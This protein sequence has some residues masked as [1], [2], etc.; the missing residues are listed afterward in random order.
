MSN[1]PHFGGRTLARSQALQLLFQAEAGDRSVEDVLDDGP[2]LESGPLDPYGR[3][4]ALG[5]EDM[6]AELDSVIA[7]RSVGWSVDRM[8]AVDRNLLRIALYEMLRVDEVDIA[9]AI[10]E[11][12]ELEKAYGTDESPRF[13]NGLLGVVADQIEEGKDPV[14]TAREQLRAA[15]K[16]VPG[17]CADA[18]DADE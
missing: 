18:G 13:A 5:V 2:C 17:E 7:A 16:H 14:A 9:V 11:C 10:D 6:L 12:V 8:P 1:K 4:L 3:E 15:G